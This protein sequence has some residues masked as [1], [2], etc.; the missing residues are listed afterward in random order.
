M[1]NYGEPSQPKLETELIRY[2]HRKKTKIFRPIKSWSSDTVDEMFDS[3][4]HL[5]ERKIE[6]IRRQDL[7]EGSRNFLKTMSKEIAESSNVRMEV[8]PNVCRLLIL[9]VNK[10]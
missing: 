8:R 4:L 7:V 10:T 5:S 1:I 2:L 6:A 3:V 9:N